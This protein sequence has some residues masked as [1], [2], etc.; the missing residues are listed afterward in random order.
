NGLFDPNSNNRVAGYMFN[1][2]Q[3]SPTT[4]AQVAG[5]VEHVSLRGST[6]DF[7]ADFVPNGGAQA[8]IGRNLSYTPVSGSIGLIQ[9]L[10]GDLVA[11]ITGQYVERAPKPAE[12]FS[13]GEHHAT[14]TFDIGNPNLKVEKAQTIELGL[15]KAK[16]RFRFEATAFYTRFDN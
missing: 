9:Q 3:F 1:E 10:P 7:P 13:R 5:R 12:L 15:R 8:A 14:G 6:P 2:L 16:G 11:S 4:K